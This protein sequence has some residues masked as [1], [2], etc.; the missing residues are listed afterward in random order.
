MALPLP[1]CPRLIPLVR[2]LARQ[3]A[4]ETFA[5]GTATDTL[6]A[7]PRGPAIVTTGTATS[8]EGW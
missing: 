5:C 8:S 4:A 7:P 6:T 2:A 3:A 1:P